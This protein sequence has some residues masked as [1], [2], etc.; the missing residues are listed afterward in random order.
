MGSSKASYQRG[1]RGAIK[2]GT[3]K[4]GGTDVVKNFDDLIRTQSILNVKGKSDVLNEKMTEAEMKDAL[5]QRLSSYWS[6]YASIGIYPNGELRVSNLDFD[7]RLRD[8][9]STPEARAFIDALNSIKVDTSKT[10]DLAAM[11]QEVQSKV[12]KVLSKYN[13]RQRYEILADITGITAQNEAYRAEGYEVLAPTRRQIKNGAEE[14]RNRFS[15]IVQHRLIGKNGESSYWQRSSLSEQSVNV[16]RAIARYRANEQ[17]KSAID[18]QVEKMR[19]FAEAKKE[20]A[21]ISVD[22]KENRA[23]RPVFR[24]MH[25]QSETGEMQPSAWGSIPRTESGRAKVFTEIGKTYQSIPNM[26]VRRS[27]KDPKHY[28]VYEKLSDGVK[29]KSGGF[30]ITEAAVNNSSVREGQ[31]RYDMYQRAG[32]IRDKTGQIV[33]PIGYWRHRSNYESAVRRNLE[34]PPGV[35]EYWSQQES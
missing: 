1:R 29:V 28:I 25:K 26:S 21:R 15:D 4:P 32:R 16:D 2:A 17:L 9:A 27:P 13:Q 18:A 24:E 23:L 3:W 6:E 31:I 7:G 22:R 20:R 8:R 5:R 35:R 11:Q 19:P 30:Y 12:D 14:L 34:I 33:R 10:G